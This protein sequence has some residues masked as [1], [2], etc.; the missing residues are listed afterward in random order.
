[1]GSKSRAGPRFKEAAST[2]TASRQTIKIGILSD[3][4]GWIDPNIR[5]ILAD[6]DWIVHAGDVMGTSVLETLGGLVGHR[7]VVAVAG[8]NDVGGRDAHGDSL[9]ATAEIPLPGGTLVVTH[10]DQF[11]AS[12][13]H[14]SLREAWPKARTVVYGHTHRL[15]CDQED[16][17]WVLNPGAAGR[18]RV[19]E[20]PSCLMLTV[21]SAGWTVETHQFE[22]SNES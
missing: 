8:N 22:L 13:A 19:H 1:M 16:L 17:P 2:A 21:G 11:G 18:I 20:G 6:A 7:R 10:G 12:P 4:H 3:T 9:P 5:E 15:V 14:E